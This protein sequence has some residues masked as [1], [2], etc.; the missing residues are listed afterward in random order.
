MDLVSI[1]LVMATM[2]PIV[3]AI[4]SIA[5]TGS[6]RRPAF[7]MAVG[8]LFGCCLRP[9]PAAA[10]PQPMLDVRLF[11]NPRLQRCRL[12]NLLSVFS[13]VG[14]LFFVSQHLQLVLGQTPAWRPA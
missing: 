5:T 7:P 9:P 1:L 4:K 10:A 6:T 13:L 11:R 8:L 2:V 3:Y 12:A 14:F